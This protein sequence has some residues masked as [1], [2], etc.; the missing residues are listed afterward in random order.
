MYTTQKQVREAFWREFPQ[1]SREKITSYNGKGKMYTTDT[2][3]AFVDW[4][5]MLQKDGLLKEG[6]AHRVTL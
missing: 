4:V 2:R 1:L 3:C 6:L 5:D